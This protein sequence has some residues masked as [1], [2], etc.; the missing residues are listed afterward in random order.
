MT[1]IDTLSVVFF[2]LIDL[3][4]FAIISYLIFYT[5]CKLHHPSWLKSLSWLFDIV[6]QFLNL[7]FSLYWWCLFTPLC[8]INSGM[9]VVLNPQI[10]SLEAIRF[11]WSFG[12]IRALAA[13]R[14]GK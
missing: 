6:N 13:N 5:Y 1:G 14:C 4:L 2:V 7:F 12:W 11:L 9:M 3:A 10:R 8:E